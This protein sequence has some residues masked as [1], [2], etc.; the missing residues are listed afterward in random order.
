LPRCFDEDFAKAKSVRE[1]GA[2]PV[3]LPLL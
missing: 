1:T 3:Q 2:N